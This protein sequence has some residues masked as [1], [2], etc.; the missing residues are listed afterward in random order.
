[1][2]VIVSHVGLGNVG[3]F[4]F[5]RYNEGKDSTFLELVF[6]LGLHIIS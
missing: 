1:V 3:S 2:N 5:S 6:L 4:P